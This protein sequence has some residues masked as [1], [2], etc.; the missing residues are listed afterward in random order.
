MSK[1][2][3]EVLLPV[4]TEEAT[5]R[6]TSK[7]TGLTRLKLSTEEVEEFVTTSLVREDVEVTRM[8]VDRLLRDDE[9][10][11]EPRHENGLLVVPVIE[12]VAVVVKRIRI[13]EELHVKVRQHADQR[14]ISVLLR[15]QKATVERMPVGGGY[16]PNPQSDEESGES[17]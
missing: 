8:P 12:E 5:I 4:A 11:P 13:V 9:P 17:K 15:K 10:A 7:T 6:K 3:E 14:D 16:P 2:P 1:T